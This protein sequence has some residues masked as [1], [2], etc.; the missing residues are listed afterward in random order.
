MLRYY[1]S[2]ILAMLVLGPSI[3]ISDAL[4]QQCSNVKLSQ[5]IPAYGRI[6]GFSPVPDG[7]DRVAFMGDLETDEIFELFTVPATG[8]TQPR[9]FD[10]NTTREQGLAGLPIFAPGGARAVFR[11]EFDTVGV[12]ELYSIATTDGGGTPVKLNGPLVGD[13]QAEF[14]VTPDRQNVVYL[15]KEDSNLE[16]LYVVPLLGGE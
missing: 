13:V 12:R 9:R 6:V 15:A 3:V 16:E 7:S 1:P 11:G 4:A 10:L 2:F 14:A 8:A 5:P